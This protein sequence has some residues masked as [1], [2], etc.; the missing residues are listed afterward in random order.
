MGLD[1]A[2][3]SCLAKEF[4][5]S[6]NL[7][8]EKKGT[9]ACDAG[10]NALSLGLASLGLANATKLGGTQAPSSVSAIFSGPGRALAVPVPRVDS[11]L[12]ALL[13]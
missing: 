1:I 3:Q 4:L 6:S 7:A 5:R 10:S 9:L 13:S 11:G 8:R 2:F 12:L